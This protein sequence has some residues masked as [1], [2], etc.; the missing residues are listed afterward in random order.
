MSFKSTLKLD[1]KLFDETERKRIL[2]APVRQSAKEFKTDLKN[3]MIFGP[4][5]GRET[6][7]GKESGDGFTRK[8]RASRR[9]ERPAPD[10]NSLVNSIEDKPLSEFSAIVEV[11]KPYTDSSGEEVLQGKLG[12]KIMTSEDVDE[13][14]K[15][16][17]DRARRALI[18]LL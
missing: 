2:A 13:A 9:G 1:S 7:R 6:T 4:H 17:N 18:S 8:H 11:T 5:T 14:E 12:R 3:K 16:F 15:K 10:T